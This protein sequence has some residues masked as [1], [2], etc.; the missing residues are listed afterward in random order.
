MKKQHRA[1]SRFQNQ[2]HHNTDDDAD[3]LFSNTTCKFCRE[4]GHW[5]KECKKNPD[6][7]Q[8]TK[9]IGME[10][11]EKGGGKKGGGKK[12]GGKKGGGKKGGGKSKG[13]KPWYA[14]KK[15]PKK[16]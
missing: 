14:K 9:F 15:K 8:G 12:G 11:H 3:A 16:G 13:G 6:N 4:E 10:K 5:G 2:N 1:H 7:W